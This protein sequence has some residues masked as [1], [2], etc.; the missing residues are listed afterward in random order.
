MKLIRA[1][2]RSESV[3]EKMKNLAK[4]KLRAE[5]GERRK[6]KGRL[7]GEGGEGPGPDS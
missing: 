2:E 7:G 6:I 1:T 5:E 4:K 3:G